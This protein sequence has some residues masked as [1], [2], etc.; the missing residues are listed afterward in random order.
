VPS[1]PSSTRAILSTHRSEDRL[2]ELIRNLYSGDFVSNPA[3][4][5]ELGLIRSI[6][7]A[8]YH[9]QLWA[10]FGWTSSPWLPLLR[11]RALILHADNDPVIP[12][13]NAMLLRSLIR[14][15]SLRKISGGGHLFVLTRPEASAQDIN[16]FL[17]RSDQAARRPRSP[18]IDF[19]EESTT[20]GT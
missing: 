15:S 12:Y 20:R 18:D 5:H 11:K 1:R 14:G 3:L 17:D 19:T 10:L 16:E 9:R 13:P 8:A 4:A 7:E 2:P 6:D